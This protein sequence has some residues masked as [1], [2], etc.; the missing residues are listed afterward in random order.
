MPPPSPS[1]PIPAHIEVHLP[2]NILG[3]RSHAAENLAETLSAVQK[4]VSALPF[5]SDGPLPP[6]S[7]PPRVQRMLICGV[8]DA[9]AARGDVETRVP[10][11]RVAFT[12]HAYTCVAASAYRVR[13]PDGL[14]RFAAVLELPSA[15]L[16]GLWET[17]EFPREVKAGLLGYIATGCFLS[18]RG[19]DANVVTWNR[20]VL[21][22]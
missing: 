1:R 3:P 20:Y 9:Q 14:L 11:W 19:V 18:A 17:L 22:L 21:E 4:V 15:S 5:V 6:T 8:A 2:A 7:H 12:I 16:E 10:F 13:V